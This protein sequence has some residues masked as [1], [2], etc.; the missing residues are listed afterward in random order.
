M[1]HLF[2][3]KESGQTKRRILEAAIDMFSQNGYSAVSVREITKQVGIKE[4]ALYNHYKTK[5]EILESIYLLFKNM[6]KNNG[7]GFPSPE[8]LQQIL[9]AVSLEAFL[10]QGFD[11]FIRAI[12]NPL[13]TKI[14]R[15]L[16]IEQYRDQRA[17]EIILQYIYKD[18]I[19]FLTSAFQILIPN[20]QI[21]PYDA[22]LLAIEY[23]YP[24]FAMM[25]EYLLLKFD[26][27]ETDEL[28][29]RVKSHIHYFT[30]IVKL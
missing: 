5:D 27:K 4:S 9:K 6:Q 29:K 8:Q 15:I 24:I 21:K 14:W 16:N 13:L 23:Q 10:E 25:T 30:E 22:K 11:Q 1:D 20:Q 19:D 3:V 2:P 28:E 18:T 26:D 7:Q 17:R 12:E